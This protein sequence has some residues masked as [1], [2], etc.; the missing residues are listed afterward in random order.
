MRGYCE[1]G[2]LKIAIPPAIERTIAMTIAKRGLSTNVRE[3]VFISSIDFLS[4]SFICF[5]YGS[6]RSISPFCVL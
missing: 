5:S 3:N 2:N 4:E 1:I 6:M